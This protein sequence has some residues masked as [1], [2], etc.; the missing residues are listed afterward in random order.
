MIWGGLSHR[1]YK[2]LAIK[3]EQLSVSAKPIWTTPLSRT[4]QPTKPQTIKIA[5]RPFQSNIGKVKLRKVN[6]RHL[7]FNHGGLGANS[8][9]P[10]FVVIVFL[11]GVPI[12]NTNL[13]ALSV[14]RVNERFVGSEPPIRLFWHTGGTTVRIDL[15][16]SEAT[17]LGEVLQ[18][19]VSYIPDGSICYGV[20]GKGQPLSLVPS[21]T[22][23]EILE[24]H[25]EGGLAMY[26]HGNDYV[27]KG[28]RIKP[29]PEPR[30]RPS[31]CLACIPPD[32]HTSTLTLPCGVTRNVI[33][34][35]GMIANVRATDSKPERRGRSKLQA[36][37]V[38]VH[39]L[40]RGA[41]SVQG[42]TPSHE[43]I[44]VEVVKPSIV[45]SF[46]DQGRTMF[47]ACAT[48][49]THNGHKIAF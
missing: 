32:T 6:W 18:K 27:Y 42:R 14:E 1:Y 5:N 43:A 30:R 9:L 40:R 12:M 15:T 19:A 16:V 26:K 44:W 31:Y 10:M 8:L 23:Q 33:G 35:T 20:K 24:F 7:I 36:E 4:V 29:F 47:L 25:Q 41:I 11:G 38:Q 17:K 21:A 34:S 2:R 13:P 48:R 45:M 46:V 22:M 3:N 28:W 49:E 39:P 37:R